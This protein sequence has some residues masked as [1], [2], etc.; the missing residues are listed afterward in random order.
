MGLFQEELMKWTDGRK[1]IF[2]NYSLSAE[3]WVGSVM[4]VGVLSQITKLCFVPSVLPQ[5]LLGMQLPP[6]SPARRHGH[7]GSSAR[8]IHGEMSSQ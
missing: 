6:N 3:S 8:W 5:L 7:L 4:G 1:E 2:L